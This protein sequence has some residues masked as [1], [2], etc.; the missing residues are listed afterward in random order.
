MK[1]QVFG[2]DTLPDEFDTK[3][4]LAKKIKPAFYQGKASSPR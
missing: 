2:N 3:K 1:T 4:I